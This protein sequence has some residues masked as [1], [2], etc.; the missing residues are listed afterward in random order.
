M[1]PASGLSSCASQCCSS[2]LLQRHDSMPSFRRCLL[3]T[4]K[5]T[6]L[7]CYYFH[8][9]RQTNHPSTQANAKWP[10]PCN[11]QNQQG[12]SC[13]CSI[14]RNRRYF[15]QCLRSM[16]HSHC[17]HKNGTPTAIQWHPSQTENYKANDILTVQSHMK[18]SKAFDMH[19]HWI[20]DQIE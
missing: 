14:S 15:S 7:M 20:K 17:S 19:Y 3:G 12:C 18:L 4:S 8:S 9:H 10:S 1:Q 6:Q 16:P 13:F 5:R 2:L 11:D